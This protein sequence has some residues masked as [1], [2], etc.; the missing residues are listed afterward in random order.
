MY[1]SDYGNFPRKWP[2]TPT[3]RIFQTFPEGP[4]LTPSPD[5]GSQGPKTPPSKNAY[6]NYFHTEG[7]LTP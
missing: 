5:G 6:E 1:S 3:F 7:S 4:Q 2:E